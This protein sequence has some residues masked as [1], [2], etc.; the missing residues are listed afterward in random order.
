MNFQKIEEECERGKDWELEKAKSYIRDGFAPSHWE[1]KGCEETV[2]E[3]KI[4]K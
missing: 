3:G 4:I 1:G 2:Q